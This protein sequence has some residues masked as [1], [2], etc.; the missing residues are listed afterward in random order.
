M[1]CAETIKHACIADVEFFEYLEK[2]VDDIFDFNATICEHIAEK[3][4]EIKYN[5]VMQDEKEKSLREVLN[6]GHTVGRA[7]ETVSDYKFITRRGTFY[8]NCSSS[9]V[10][11]HNGIYFN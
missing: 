11:L 10:R 4:C 5:V 9:S 2:H 7:I 1:A 3:N 6:L 8:W